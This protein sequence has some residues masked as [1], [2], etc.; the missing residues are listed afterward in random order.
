MK[1]TPKSITR[2]KAK[3]SSAFELQHAILHNRLENN[4]SMMGSKT[5]TFNY[6]TKCLYHSK[7][8]MIQIL[9][10]KWTRSTALVGGNKEL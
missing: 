9:S 2:I 6:R 7:R 5:S 3:V 8:R 10:Q 1:A 4:M